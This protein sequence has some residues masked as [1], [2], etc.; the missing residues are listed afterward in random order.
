MNEG[1][2]LLVIILGIPLGLIVILATIYNSLVQGRNHCDEAWA[3]IDA[4]LKRR[5]DLIPN[6]V[7]TV[8]AYAKHEREL[9]ESVSRAR[10]SAMANNGSPRSQA[11]DENALVRGVR[12]VL[13]VAENY[14]ELKANQNYLALQT[15]LANTEDRIQRSRRFYNANVRDYLNLLQRFP[16]NLVAGSFH[17]TPREFF[18]IEEAAE[19]EAPTVPSA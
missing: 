10:A 9:F 19:R 18:E 14:P 15:E 4:E 3:D 5:Y 1:M 11:G 2:V 6:L 13:A 16:T 8:Q 7:R 12:Q 17:F